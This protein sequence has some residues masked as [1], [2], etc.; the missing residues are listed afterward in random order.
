MNAHR[1]PVVGRFLCAEI[2]CGGTSRTFAENVN[3]TEQIRNDTEVV[4][5][6]SSIPDGRG[7]PDEGIGPYNGMTRLSL[8]R[9][10]CLCMKGRR[11]LRRRKSGGQGR[12]PPC[13]NRV[14]IRARLTAPS[15]APGGHRKETSTLHAM[16]M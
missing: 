11:I 10:L 1:R 3:R 13:T 5:Y 2:Y 16:I 7:R 4:P 15:H 9:K 8:G 6:K 12:K 14:T